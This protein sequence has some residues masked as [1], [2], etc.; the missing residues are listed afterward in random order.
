MHPH[1]LYNHEVRPTTDRFLSPGQVGVLNGWGVFSTLR[2]K[3]GV[4]FAWDRHLARMRRDAQLLHVPFPEDPHAELLLP[5][6]RLVEINHAFESTLR[7]AVLRNMGGAFDAPGQTRVYDVIAFTKDLANWGRC[8]RLGLEPE[9]RHRENRFRGTKMLSWCFN[10]TWYESARQRGLDE[11]V[12]L[13]ERGE[14]SELTSA[15]IFAVFGNEIATPPLDSGCLP[16]ITREVLL[17]IPIPG[18]RAVERTLMPADL[19]A[20]DEV[21]I[22]SSTRDTLPVEWID[23]LR[24]RFQPP[25]GGRGRGAAQQA[26][27]RYLEDTCQPQSHG[28]KIGADVLL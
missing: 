21:F 14:V 24:I 22:T 10:L 18:F 26:L 11:V 23:T 15:N 13:N 19:E 3:N 2:V 8:V 7:V 5:L 16:G 17:E 6:L 20:A 27:T 25:D 28:S 12:L 4:L 1:L 9:A